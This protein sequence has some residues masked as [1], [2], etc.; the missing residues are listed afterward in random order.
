MSFESGDELGFKA[1]VRIERPGLPL[2][3]ELV[4]I[5]TITHETRGDGDSREPAF[6]LLRPN[7]YQSFPGC[8]RHA[9]ISRITFRCA[10]ELLALQDSGKCPCVFRDALVSD[11][12]FLFSRVSLQ[13]FLN[14]ERGGTDF[15]AGIRSRPGRILNI[16]LF[17]SARFLSRF[18]SDS[19]NVARPHVGPGWRIVIEWIRERS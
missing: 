2:C 3:R 9:R 5:L 12:P 8:P 14:V 7:L 16:L 10:Q 18:C 6:Q 15:E 11:I 17:V 19:C 13:V 1:A 4:C